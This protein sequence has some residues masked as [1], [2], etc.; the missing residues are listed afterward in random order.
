MKST[1]ASYYSDVPKILDQ[2]K[3]QIQCFV[4]S[5]ISSTDAI[6]SLL[7]SF[8]FLNHDT[9]TIYQQDQDNSLFLFLPFYDHILF[10][11][12]QIETVA[13][14]L[15]RLARGEDFQMH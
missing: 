10:S 5:L 14:K 12:Q 2:K 4:D 9:V 3:N 7:G 13:F 11:K 8:F 1:E 6:I 15:N